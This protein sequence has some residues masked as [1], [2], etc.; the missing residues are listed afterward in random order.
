MVPA[1][2]LLGS[3]ILGPFG[4]IAVILAA[5]TAATLLIS[6][7]AHGAEEQIPPATKTLDEQNDAKLDS[8][9]SK[10]NYWNPLN[11]FG[12]TESLGTFVSNNPF[13]V[14]LATATTSFLGVIALSAKTR[15]AITA[16][17]KGGSGVADAMTNTIANKQVFSTIAMSF[18]KYMGLAGAIGGGALVGGLV[19]KL[20]GNQDLITTGMLLGGLFVGAFSNAILTAI[21]KLMVQMGALLAGSI[22]GIPVWVAATV[23]AVIA[24]GVGTLGLFLF[25]KEGDLSKDFTRLK[26][27]TMSWLKFWES[28]KDKTS[29]R[30]GLT[31]NQNQ[32]ASDMGF[33]LDYSLEGVDTGKLSKIETDKLTSLKTALGGAIN[34][35]HFEKVVKGKLEGA[36][37]ESINS[38][39]NDLKKYA[40]SLAQTE[41]DFVKRLQETDIVSPK[42]RVRKWDLAFTDLKLKASY[43]MQMR[44]LEAEESGIVKYH[45]LNRLEDESTYYN[46]LASI[47]M[48][49]KDLSGD[50][51]TKYNANWRETTPKELRM[52]SMAKYLK[53]ATMTPQMSAQY[54][55]SAKSII[56]LREARNDLDGVVRPMP[57]RLSSVFSNSTL[58]VD[59][60]NLLRG[61]GKTEKDQF[62]EINKDLNREIDDM[63]ATLDRI[64]NYNLHITAVDNFTKSIAGLDS[65]FKDA[66]IS[67]D[68]S[69]IFAKDDGAM[70]RLEDLR[71]ESLRLASDMKNAKS[72]GD[73]QVIK[74][75]QEI[76]TNEI[77]R[78]KLEADTTSP[79]RKQFLLGDIAGAADVLEGISKKTFETLSDNASDSL[80][81]QITNIR[82]A[83]ES[84]KILPDMDPNKVLT[85]QADTLQKIADLTKDIDALNEKRQH[86]SIVGGL[87]DYVG[88]LFGKQPAS[89]AQMAY[90]ESRKQQ[91]RATYTEQARRS[92]VSSEGSPQTVQ[93]DYLAQTR[94]IQEMKMAASKL[95]YESLRGTNRGDSLKELAAQASVELPNLV[96]IYGDN[97]DTLREKLIDMDRTRQDIEQALMNSDFAGYLKL[98]KKYEVDK[99]VANRKPDNV[100]TAISNAS[101]FGGAS[102]DA[103]NLKYADPD[104]LSKL[105]K[106]VS[107]F[108]FN[109]DLNQNTS[110]AGLSA[111][112]KRQAAL[113]AEMAALSFKAMKAAAKTFGGK[114]SILEELGYSPDQ[115]R[116]VGPELA[117]A[118]VKSSVR[119]KELRDKL[120]RTALE[121]IS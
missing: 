55:K 27:E 25:G 94:K 66:G 24:V 62:S 56:K 88:N 73:K 118:L 45:Q 52:Q 110:G 37:V 2:G 121:P 86:Q 49:I 101:S 96:R 72:I 29:S 91:E 65:A 105:S 11:Y 9:K 116:S 57:M 20:T 1:Q 69:A 70:A 78:I 113:A 43:N 22:L 92:F 75:R 104:A 64:N 107:D 31:V 41:F 77:V 80:F 59:T 106:K 47:R 119:V 63:I 40:T 10:K 53:D 112:I 93:T 39:Q 98:S 3:I 6:S 35:A 102:I 26:E 84:L 79:F 68:S 95:L 111:F 85:Q 87:Y 46:K 54:E 44:D 81:K 5:V 30:T 18:T 28:K 51:N 114:F 36:T 13:K 48:K 115:I 100:T 50:K 76:I 32:Q 16:A 120:A 83:Q 14:I 58:K 21:P 71:M 67:F 38:K 42:Q 103:S 99:A 4:K 34:D 8:A 109:A 7:L 97:F 82:V 12:S 108:N 15:D 90:E 19:A 89:D 17:F 33:N 74:Q 23:A 61:R 60:Q 117:N